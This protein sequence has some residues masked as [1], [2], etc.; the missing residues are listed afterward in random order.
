ML[1]YPNQTFNVMLSY[2]SCSGWLSPARLCLSP[3][4]DQRPPGVDVSLLVVHGI[5]LPPQKFGGPYIDQLFCNQLKPKEHHYFSEIAHL[6]VSAHALIRRNG[7]LVQ[8]VSLNERAWHAGVSSYR[9]RSACND[10]S[11]GIE[12]EGT[13]DC[14]YEDVQYRQLAAVYY[15]IADAH[16]A[17]T[18]ERI[19]GHSD[20]A[21]G[22]KT[23]PGQAFSWQ[24]F[25]HYLD[26][27]LTG[28]SD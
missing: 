27:Q 20:I 26:L 25:N 8:Y 10:Y 19:A 4:H 9:G 23:D 28:V 2:D 6:R 18:R 14:D 1:V 22:R 7:E 16:P 24:L 5:S 12:L 13:D 3:N 11:V 21:P 15:A 17:M